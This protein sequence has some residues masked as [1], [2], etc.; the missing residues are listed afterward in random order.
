MLEDKTLRIGLLLDFYGPLLTEKQ[1][2]MVRAH[3]EDDLSLGELAEE[4][5]VSRAAVHDLVHRAVEAL[6]GY[7]ARLGLIGKYLRERREL[8]RCLE[9]LEE[10]G[11]LYLLL[12]EGSRSAES[13]RA[14][15]GDTPG[16]MLQRLETAK[17]V[18]RGLL[19]S[20]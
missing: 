17:R 18:I 15:E 5:G 13:S 4:A 2:E 14:G 9:A 16:E 12:A 20:E 1:R 19:E 3:F 10:V 7:E 11:R 8:E 6:E